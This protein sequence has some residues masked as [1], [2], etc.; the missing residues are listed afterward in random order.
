MQTYINQQAE[1]LIKPE[2]LASFIDDVAEDIKQIDENRIAGLG[3]SVRVL[4]QW[5]KK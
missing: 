3:V 4:K 2:D 5:L 1:Q